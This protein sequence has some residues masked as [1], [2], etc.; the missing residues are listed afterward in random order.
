[1]SIVDWLRKGLGYVLLTMGV[2]RPTTKPVVRPVFP[3][4]AGDRSAGTSAP[5]HEGPLPPR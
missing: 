2:S 5:D 4:E 1:M 3:S